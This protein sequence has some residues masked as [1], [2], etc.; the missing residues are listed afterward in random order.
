MSTVFTTPG[1]ENSATKS[2]FGRTV[3]NRL[4]GRTGSP[5]QRSY[6][7]LNAQRLA[8]SRSPEME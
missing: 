3:V 2:S 1:M 6:A 4:A 8:H 5:A 7:R